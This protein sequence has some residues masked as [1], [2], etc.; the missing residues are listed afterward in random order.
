MISCLP[1]DSMITTFFLRKIKFKIWRGGYDWTQSGRSILSWICREYWSNRLVLL[2]HNIRANIFRFD[3][4][5]ILAIAK[6]HTCTNISTDSDLICD[7]NATKEKQMTRRT[8]NARLIRVMPSSK[9]H[10]NTLQ[11]F[12]CVHPIRKCQSRS[13]CH[14][15]PQM[16]ELVK[17]SDIWHHHTENTADSEKPVT[18]WSTTLRYF[19]G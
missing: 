17:V 18:K 8:R 7:R 3:I 12:T 1:K 9:G 2:F 16:P 14:F 11:S 19:W 13:I 15:L 4:F 5:L 10:L 6:F